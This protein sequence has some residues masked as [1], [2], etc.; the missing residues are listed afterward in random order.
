MPL[1]L[2]LDWSRDGIAAIEA[3]IGGG[4]VRVRRTLRFAWP[5]ALSLDHDAA[6]VGDWLKQELARAGVTATETRVVL[7][8]EELVTR[9]LDLPSAPDEELPELVR[10]QAAT[11]A[12]VPLDQLALDFVPL[13]QGSEAEGRVALMVSTDRKQLDVVRT[14]CGAAGLELQSVQGSPFT[15]AE[16]AVHSE[17]QRGED[18]QLA[19]LVVF[20]DEHRVEISILQSL[21][22][23]FSHH[24]RASMND[25]RAIR[26][27][28]AEINRSIV[29]LG[30]SM[31]TTFEVARVCLIHDGEVDPAL[32][33][34]LAQRFEGRLHVID[35]A[36]DSAVETVSPDQAQKLGGLAP[37]F[38]A[39]LSDLQ[40][41]VPAIDLLNPR[42]PPVKRDERKRQMMIGG[43]IAAAALLLL[44]VSLWMYGRGLDRQ[45][46]NLTSEDTELTDILKNG[47]PSLNS[48]KLVQTWLAAAI[49]PLAEAERLNRL[50]PGPETILLLGLNV[51]PGRNDSIATLTGSG[52]AR[53]ERDIHELFQKLSDNGY[54]VAPQVTSRE[55]PD[56]D[57]PLQFTLKADRLPAPATNTPEKSAAATTS[58]GRSAN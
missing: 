52:I 6:A 57:Y 8:R 38:G 31:H 26:G 30:Q 11:K 17:R 41:T 5:E 15:V 4:R 19:T 20:Q 2:A 36:T 22:L 44:G 1:L 55:S 46:Q 50:L 37:A 49:D 53:T 34:A 14:V 21:G 40:R 10:F 56:P 29:V 35:P 42:K 12:T 33:Q 23:L 28:M 51:T 16:V 27:T 9:R 7:S 24:T 18:P 54:R 3:D 47:Q 13:P 48:H 25:E 43:S 58:A 32:E 39:L 45:I